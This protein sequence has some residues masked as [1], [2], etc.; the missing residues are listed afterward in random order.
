[1]STAKHIRGIIKKG[2]HATIKD[3]PAIKSEERAETLSEE[4]E[5]TLHSRLEEEQ[6]SEV[7]AWDI[8]VSVF[9]TL[10]S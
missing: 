6:R 9:K 3:L 4:F 8:S 5:H 2:E 7:T 10:Q 1:M